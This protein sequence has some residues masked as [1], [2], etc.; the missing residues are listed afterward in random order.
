[1]A[2][3]FTSLLNALKAQFGENNI[4]TVAGDNVGDV[5]DHVNRLAQTHFD[6]RIDSSQATNTQPLT[7]QVCFIADEECDLIGIQVSSGISVTT[8]N[9]DRFNLL[10]HKRKAST[11]S[12]TEA[13]ASLTSQS[14]G[15][16]GTW[17]NNGA[18][19]VNNALL[20]TTTTVLDLDP[21]DVITV[22]A[23]KTG[24]GALVPEVRFKTTVREKG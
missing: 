8:S 4:R 22:S 24:L 17:I 5:S 15:A 21:G 14:G 18:H 1:M 10:F 2:F 3:G 23:T 6:Y 12:A 11:W 9:T 16:A 13:V 20:A 19:K 7:A